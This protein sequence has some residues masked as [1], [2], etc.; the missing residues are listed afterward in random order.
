MPE[1]RYLARRYGD[2]TKVRG[3]HVARDR[4]E[5]LHWLDDQSLYPI[6]VSERSGL[7][8]RGRVRPYDLA[9]F[10]REL[11]RLLEAGMP[12]LTVL[13]SI[14]T[15]AQN[16]HLRDLVLLMM[17][18]I[19]GGGSMSDAWREHCTTFSEIGEAVVA[20]GESSGRLPTMLNS[21]AAYLEESAA[22][23]SRVLA[24]LW[25]PSVLAGTA[26][27]M[28]TLFIVAVLPRFR[29][30]LE[31]LGVELPALTRYVMAVGDFVSAYWLLILVLGLGALFALVVAARRPAARLLLDTWVLRL[32]IVGKLVELSC[33]YRFAE[34]SA[35]LIDSG[36]PATDAFMS[37]AR[38]LPNRALR[39]QLEQATQEMASG[40][41]VSEA[42][43]GHNLLFPMAL[44]MIHVGEIS[45]QLPEM[46]HHLADL[47][48]ESL[49]RQ[50]ARLST[51]LEPAIIIPIAGV[52]ATIVAAMLLPYFKL[53]ET[54]K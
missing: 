19:E 11:A 1:Y 2:G 32:P 16:R 49:S 20:A 8:R 6:E 17:A 5:L 38:V 13:N 21:L 25:Y 39:G 46:L 31:S 3:R 53:V 36:L 22:L 29:L 51:F 15:H 7:V 18:E 41:T 45:G 24:T 40:K 43:S 9:I 27:G 10:C 14:G 28:T 4:E 44:E 33:T 35:V 34:T 54:L 52:V 30:L 37:T 26:V 23:R 42:M 47:C 48:N 50:V 12:L